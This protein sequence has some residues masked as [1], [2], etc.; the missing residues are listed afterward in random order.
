VLFANLFKGK[1]DLLPLYR[2]LES[3]VQTHLSDIDLIPTKTYISIE[4]KRIFAC[5][6]PMKSTGRDAQSDAHDRDRRAVAGERFTGRIHA[7]GV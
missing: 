5:A 3:L 2:A 4:G 6:T 7:P 1:D